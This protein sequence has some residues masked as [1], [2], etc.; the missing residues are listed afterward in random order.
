MIVK[1]NES[2]KTLQKLLKIGDTVYSVTREH[3]LRSSARV[4]AF[5]VIR[6]SKI[7]DI[8]SLIVKSIE[9]YRWSEEGGGIWT[10]NE[11][12]VLEAVSYL[13][14]GVESRGMG[15]KT[16]SKKIDENNFQAGHTLL[17]QKL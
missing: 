3:S 11:L 13:V 17:H 9:N 8:S 15:A 14:H 4:V 1:L 7:I 12:A 10:S 5:Y 2:Q 6:R 16:P